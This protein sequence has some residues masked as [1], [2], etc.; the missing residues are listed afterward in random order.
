MK[1][2]NFIKESLNELAN[3]HWGDILLDKKL[4]P[5]REDLKT[6]KEQGLKCKNCTLSKTRDKFVF[7]EGDKKAELMFIGE[8]PGYD[9]DKTGRPFIGRAGQ[10]LTKIVTAMGLTRES[11]YIANIVKCH[12]MIDP[13]QPNKRGNDRKPTKEEI[14]QCV[15]WLIK[16]IKIIKP[17]VLCT[18]GSVAT[19]TILNLTDPISKLR[20]NEFTYCNV[21]VIPTFHPAYLLRNPKEKKLVWEDMQKIMKIIEQLKK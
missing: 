21:T 1:K 20:G 13:T 19:Q 15:P 5:K 12:P 14:A 17:K 8:G 9:E 10:L 7:G 4:P 11:V 16:Q 18:L 2:K 6:L 3:E